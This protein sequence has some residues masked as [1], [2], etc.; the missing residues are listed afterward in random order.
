MSRDELWIMGFSYGLK[1]VSCKF[2]ILHICIVELFMRMNMLI[3][4]LML[5]FSLINTGILL[6]SSKLF[7]GQLF[8]LPWSLALSITIGSRG[9]VVTPNLVLVNSQALEADGPTSMN[10]VG[11]DADFC[12]ETIAHAV[13][14]AGRGVPV[15]ACRV[16]LVH[17]LFGLGGIRS[18][19]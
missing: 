14:H 17:E 2:D 15:H 6:I 7:N 10:L 11:A 13:C 9:L 4:L 18:Q 8:M 1:W 16:N 5:I 19:D 3:W 12:A